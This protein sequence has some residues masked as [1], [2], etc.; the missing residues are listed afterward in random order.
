MAVTRHRFGLST[1][2]LSAR[3]DPGHAGPS[4]SRERDARPPTPSLRPPRTRDR[5]VGLRRD[6]VASW[7]NG[8]H[9]VQVHCEPGR[10]VEPGTRADPGRHHRRAR[11]RRRGRSMGRWRR[12]V[13]E[14]PLVWR[15][16]SVRERLDARHRAHPERRAC[17][18]GLHPDYRPAR[19]SLRRRSRRRPRLD[20]GSPARRPYQGAHGYHGIARR[21]RVLGN[22]TYKNGEPKQ[23][24]RTK[25][26]PPQPQEKSHGTTGST[27]VDEKP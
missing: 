19:R 2:T 17:R 12:D 14:L 26:R 23:A 4:H 16:S 15:G 8:Q 22:F 21:P 27:A 18:R 24:R 10:L 20:L 1:P 11:R 5:A 9:A 7:Q 13:G 25:A 3:P 6:E